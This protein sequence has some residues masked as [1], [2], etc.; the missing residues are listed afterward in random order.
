MHRYR[1]PIDVKAAPDGSPEA[2][3]WR[4]RDRRVAR[5]IGHWRDDPGWWR[6]QARQ[7]PLRVAQTDLWRV[8]TD[9]GGIYELACH[10]DHG[11]RLDRVW[12]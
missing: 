4:D 5:V 3:R 11:W 1:T 8:E 12:D 6:E 2:F 7:R 9:C 10:P